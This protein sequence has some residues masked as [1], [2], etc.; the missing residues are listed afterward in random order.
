MTR[1]AMVLITLAASSQA[2]AQVAQLN[3]SSAAAAPPRP[4]PTVF[5][6]GGYVEALYQW[7]FGNP[8][9]GLTNFRGFDNRHNSFTLSNVALDAQWDDQNLVGRL[10]LNVGHTPSTYYLNEPQ[11]A[12]TVGANDSGAELWKYVQQANT[13]YRWGARRQFTA[14]AG[15][16]LSPIG[17][18]SMAVRENWN[19]SR[20]NLFFGLPFYHTGIRLTYT[21]SE[22]WAV[23]V[24]A[25]NG[26]NSV[27]D[28]NRDKSLSTQATWTRPTVNV[29]FLYFGGVE[30][31]LGAPEGRGWRHLLDAHA[32]WQTAPW[33]TLLAHGNA[34]F[35]RTN[36]GLSHWQAAAIYAR[37][38]LVERLFFAVR[39]DAFLESVARNAAGGASSI[40]WPTPWV[41]S[42]TATLDYRPH[43]RLSAR[44][45]FRQDR[46]QDDIFFRG[47][48]AGDGR[49]T[50]FVP[51]RASQSTVTLGVTTWF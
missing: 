16:F 9:N 21:L 37:C 27:V 20:S 34:G 29:S 12:G 23:T 8:S 43:D 4:A 6:L 7:N 35:E 40:F 31:G 50:A 11:S 47:S 41:A 1:I 33:L 13:G 30:R 10:T 18:E 15:L 45:E 17:P 24:A 48:V 22:R 38:R 28:N 36:F 39:A 19:W 2:Q 32:T 46:A 26:W 5:M 3:T 51:N 42:G 25:Y 49:A 14:A 44:I